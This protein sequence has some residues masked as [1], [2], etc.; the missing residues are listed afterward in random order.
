MFQVFQLFQKYIA[1]VSYGC[2]KSISGD[3]AQV[4]NVASVFRGIL[5][6]LDQNVSSVSEV[7]FKHFY[8]DTAYVSHLC[9]K[10]LFEMFQLF[11]SYVAISV[12]ML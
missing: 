9:C 10:I 5:Q 1:V 2:Y 8:L 4:A 11:Q 7:R 6:A 3:V 12:F